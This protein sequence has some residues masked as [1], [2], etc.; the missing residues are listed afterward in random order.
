MEHGKIECSYCSEDED[1]CVSCNNIR[2]KLATVEKGN[3]NFYQF[4]KEKCPNCIN[5]IIEDIEYELKT[6]LILQKK[7]RVEKIIKSSCK[8]CFGYGRKLRKIEKLPCD[9]CK[10]TGKVLFY[11]KVKPLLPFFEIREYEEYRNCDKCKGNAYLEIYSDNFYIG[12]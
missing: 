2:E 6:T 11:K 4:Q 5:G 7:Y 9:H 1:F 10:K 12:N 3:I 8:K